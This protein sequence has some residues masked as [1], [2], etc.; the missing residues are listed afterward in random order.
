VFVT[1][2]VLIRDAFCTLIFL[3]KI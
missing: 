3:Q 2:V 1:K